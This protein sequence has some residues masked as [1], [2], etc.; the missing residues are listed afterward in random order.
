MF[1]DPAEAESEGYAAFWAALATGQHRS[2][3]FM[4]R[5]RDGREIW[6][7]ATYNPILDMSGRPFR[8]VKYATDVTAEKLRRADLEG[9]IA[10][11][12]KS[13]GVVTFALDGTIL[14]ANDA[15]LGILGYD[16]DELRGRHH[17]M[18]VEPAHRASADYADFWAE[19][20]AG[21]FASGL[22]KRIGQGGREVWIQATY[23]PILDL[24]GRPARIVKFASDV[25]SDVA[26][27]E[28]YEDAKRQAQHDSATALP[29][30]VRLASF[31]A[32]LLAE[33]DARLVVLYLDLDRFKPINDAFGHAAG[34]RVLGEVADRLRRALTKDQLAARVGGDEFVV[35]APDLA[36]EDIEALCQRLIDV[37]TAPIRHESGDLRVGLSI[38]IAVSPTDGRAPD[39]LLRS[40]DAALYRSKQAGRGTYS[41]HSPT[42]G[43][44]V[45]SHRAAVD[46]MRRAIAA[47]EFFLEYQPRFEARTRTVQSLEALVRWQHPE[48]GRISPADFIPLAEKCG[49][50]AQLGAWVLRTACRAA[51]TWDGVGVSVN[52]SPVQFRSGDLPEMV[53]R[54][55]ADVGLAPG[56][57]ELEVTE[58]VLLENA[59][60]A[61]SALDE[62]KTLGVRLA[63]DDFGTGYSSLSTLRSF[64]F[65]VIKIDR[66]FVAD[67]DKRRGGRE[68]V[69]A[70]LGL[71]KALG[72]SVTAEGVETE[73]QLAVLATD[74]CDEV[75]GFLLGRPMSAERV[76]DLLHAASSR[77]VG[78]SRSRHEPRRR[79]SLSPAAALFVGCPAP[80]SAAQAALRRYASGSPHGVDRLDKGRDPKVRRAIS[81][82]DRRRTEDRS[83]AVTGSDRACPRL[84]HR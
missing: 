33:P 24:A 37:A 9:Q 57:L 13:Q 50:I 80:A 17:S 62:L 54:V 51:A 2:G 79:A 27:A 19:L 15:M 35:V 49:L 23:N 14:D 71:G 72:L 38:G 69:R 61:R 78:R 12:R 45:V 81:A 16:L 43:D 74:A 41:F 7:Q 67:L 63:M 10:A 20:R 25:T 47:G 5:G 32:S 55:L 36:E 4:R 34:D 65:D 84:A 3:E 18:L 31:M 59:E 73:G 40:A 22:Y 26:L 39:D 30:R 6:L 82:V 29:N 28:A 66:Q 44:R 53:R 42:M 21:A 11:I 77:S 83:T 1:V 64:P 75:Q 60:L 48:R 56:R 70:I 8:V 76:A 52:V 68:V 58:G 46:D